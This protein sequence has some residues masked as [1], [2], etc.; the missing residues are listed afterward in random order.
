MPISNARYTRKQKQRITQ[1][2]FLPKTAFWKGAVAAFALFF[3]AGDAAFAA[4]G[5]AALALCG[6]LVFACLPC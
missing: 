3:F 1:Q 5:E 6:N 4:G 2:L